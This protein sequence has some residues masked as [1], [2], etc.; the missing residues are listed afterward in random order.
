[1]TRPV[2]VQ[3]E[4]IAAPAAAWLGERCELLRAPPA[5]AGFDRHLARAAGLVVRTYTRVDAALLARAP[6]LRVV[7]RAGV[8]LDNI[9]LDACR[10]RGVRVVHTP[11]AN[12]RA[13][14]ELVLALLLDA[15][16]PRPTLDRPL[17]REEWDR[18]RAAAIAP[19]QLAGMTLGVWGLGRVGRAVARAGVA[20]GMRVTYHDIA[21]IPV[22]ERHGAL[23]VP[24]DQLLRDSDI[25]SLH[26]DARPGNR[27]LVTREVLSLLKP[28]AI[29]VN[30]SRG[31]VVDE[32]AL[33]SHLRAHPRALALLD[34]LD[35]EPP[36]GACPLLGLPNARLTPHVGAATRPAHE[37]MSWVVRDVWRVL[38][39]QTPEFPAV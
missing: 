37:A 5:E 9:D 22:P 20:L 39:G 3:T 11:D 31:M 16:R 6:A 33:A 23:P 17:S 38:I 32:P 8:G 19:R 29:L 15:L 30:T 35:P 10:A 24:L 7:G 26:V 27:L 21:D 4:D 14:A 2:V 36:T 28:D 34:V 25:V 1:M 12:S 13:V 18:V